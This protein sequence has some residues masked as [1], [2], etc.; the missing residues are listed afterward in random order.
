MAAGLVKPCN[1][2]LDHSGCCKRAKLGFWRSAAVGF[3]VTGHRLGD[4]F[5]RLG[6]AER[7]RFKL[8]AAFI[9]AFRHL[10][11]R[12]DQSWFDAKILCTLRA[13]S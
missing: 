10:A 5:L 3:D 8:G 13:T 11:G 7:F 9:I 12:C 2:W 1:L 4:V 6:S